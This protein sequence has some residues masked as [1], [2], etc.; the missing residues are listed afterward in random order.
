MQPKAA[1][2]AE[3]ARMLEEKVIVAPVSASYPFAELK[4]ALQ[5]YDAG[6]V[7]GKI[8]VKI[9]DPGI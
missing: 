4:T 1:D 7:K 5:Q 2:L 3:I 9:E 6:G 8:G